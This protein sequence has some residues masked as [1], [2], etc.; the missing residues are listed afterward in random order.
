MNFSIF[1]KSKNSLMLQLILFFKI[2]VFIEVFLILKLKMRL[3]W[4]E[5]HLCWN[6]RHK[7]SKKYRPKY[8]KVKQFIKGQ[9]NPILRMV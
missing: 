8:H 6:F 2:G 1:A 5:A 7:K 9:N 3:N 4:M